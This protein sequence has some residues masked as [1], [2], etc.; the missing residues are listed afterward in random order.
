MSN[1]LADNKFSLK[2]LDDYRSCVSLEFIKQ[3]DV[4]KS[5]CDILKLD[6]DKALKKE[7][8]KFERCLAYKSIDK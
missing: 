3:G 6:A 2:L 7:T 4:R 1:C 8:E 5:V